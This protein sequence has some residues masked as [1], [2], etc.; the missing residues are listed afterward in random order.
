MN[1]VI[2]TQFKL[3]I[4][5][6]AHLARYP[7]NDVLMCTVGPKYEKWNCFPLFCLAHPGL[8]MT[9]PGQKVPGHKVP[10][11]KVPGHKVPNLGNIGH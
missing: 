7:E 10:G 1:S 11:H 6:I 4:L 9:N 2:K 3:K 5:N 8:Y